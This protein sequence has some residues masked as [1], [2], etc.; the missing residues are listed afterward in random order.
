MDKPDYFSQ[1]ISR[2]GRLN[3]YEEGNFDYFYFIA[4]CPWSFVVCKKE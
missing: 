1:Q 3:N 2:V 4:N